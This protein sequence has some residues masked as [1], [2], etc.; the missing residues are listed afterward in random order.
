MVRDQRPQQF[1]EPD[2]IGDGCIATRQLLHHQRIGERIRT[3]AAQRV[4]HGDA[5]QPCLGQSVI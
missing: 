4:R 3:R 2:L 1:D 5:E